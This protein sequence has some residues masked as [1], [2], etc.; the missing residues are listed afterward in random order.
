MNDI[1]TSSSVGQYCAHFSCHGQR[2]RSFSSTQEGSCSGWSDRTSKPDSSPPCLS[3][4]A[5]VI[6]GNGVIVIYRLKWHRSIEELA[7]QVTRRPWGETNTVDRCSLTPG[8]WSSFYLQEPMQASSQVASQ[9]A[10][11]SWFFFF[12]CISHS[13]K[14]DRTCCVR[15]PGQNWPSGVSLSFCTPEE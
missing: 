2:F 9:A 13:E 1:W 12:F 4:N 7:A 14:P 5:A 11:L 8:S 15:K 3:L 6:I 10:L